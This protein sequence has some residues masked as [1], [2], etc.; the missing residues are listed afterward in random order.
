MME[1]QC[2]KVFADPRP[3]HDT[4]R[5]DRLTVPAAA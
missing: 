2:I 4:V 1:F 3:H 5:I